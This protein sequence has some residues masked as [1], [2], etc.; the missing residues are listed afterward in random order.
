MRPVII[1]TI[2]VFLA[3]CTGTQTVLKQDTDDLNEVISTTTDAMRAYYAKQGQDRFDFVINFVAERPSC[4][5]S[6]S[7]VVLLQES[8]CLTSDER[9]RRLD[10]RE[11]RNAHDDCGVLLDSTLVV[12]IAPELTQ[13]RQTTITLIKVVASYQRALGRILRD[14][15]F[16]T[17]AEINDLQSRLEELNEKV[18]E[19]LEKEA[20][21]IG[22]D[23]LNQQ[24]TAVGALL[25]ILRGMEQEQADFEA[26]RGV[27]TAKGP[28]VDAALQTLLRTYVTVDLPESRRL[29]RSMLE[30]IQRAYSDMTV[31]ERAE[32][33]FE[34]RVLRLRA[35]HEPELAR[36]NAAATPDALAK[37]LRGL[38]KG[39]KQLQEAFKGNLTKEQR[40]RIADENSKQ[41]KATFQSI[42]NIVKL[43]V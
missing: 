34:E 36:I 24:V 20:S 4:G 1:P 29:E 8:R 37:A 16:D 28:A 2:L 35:I 19:F 15:T 42:L 43:F 41:L 30:R 32:L 38:I 21:E 22:S 18:S 39:H 13:P 12:R 14:D 9:R 23:E 7:L 17:A 6:S 5:G 11:D 40:Q 26:L 27:I 33:T 3:G 25:D 31:E 10:C